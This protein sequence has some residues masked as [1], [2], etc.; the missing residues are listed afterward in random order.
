MILWSRM[1][2]F[3]ERNTKNT[4]WIVNNKSVNRLVRLWIQSQTTPEL[5]STQS[6]FTS[7]FFIH[8]ISQSNLEFHFRSAVTLSDYMLFHNYHREHLNTVMNELPGSCTECNASKTVVTVKHMQIA[9]RANAAMKDR[10]LLFSCF[11]I[12]PAL[13]VLSNCFPFFLV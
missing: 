1:C 9:G 8:P 5:S 13:T 12:I 4:L 11:P 3:C 6:L 7:F 2:F 10:V